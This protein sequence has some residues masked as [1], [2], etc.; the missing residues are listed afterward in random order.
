LKLGVRTRTHVSVTGIDSHGVD[1]T[2]AAGPDRIECG[3]VLWAAG[4]GASEWGKIIGL[5]TGAT[6]DRQGRVMVEPDLSVKGH[7]EIFVIGDLS[8]LDGPDGKP[9][10]GVAPTAMQQ[11]RYV[12]KVLSGG[13]REPFHYFDKGTLAVIGRAAGVAWF[14]KFRFSGFLAWLSWLFI[15]LMYLVGFENR[16]LVFLQWGFQYFT[17]HRG[18]RLI[19]GP[20]EGGL[21]KT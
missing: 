19:T 1:I 3:T 16:I 4:V 6:L 9:L 13:K 14:G 5:R 10:P 17:F 11:G 20:G 15:H 2:T 8:H 21:D 12:A 18:A 7:P